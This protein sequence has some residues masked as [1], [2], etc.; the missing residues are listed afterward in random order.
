VQPEKVKVRRDAHLL[1]CAVSKAEHPDRSSNV[2]AVSL[3]NDSGRAVSALQSSRSRQVNV[4]MLPSDSGRVVMFP[5][6][7]MSS[8]VSAARALMESRSSVSD[9]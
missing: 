3:P 5:H 1:S 7:L 8:A 4:V 9:L 2:S 6:P